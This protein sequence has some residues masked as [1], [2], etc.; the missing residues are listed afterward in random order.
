MK[1]KGFTLVELLAVIAI[2]AILVIIAL[3]N[4]LGMFNQAKKNTFVTEVQSI[5]STG[6]TQFVSDSMGD[7][8]KFSEGIKYGRY[9]GQNIGDA[10]SGFKSLDLQGTTSIDYFIHFNLAGAV[11]AFYAT[12]GQFQFA[13]KGDGLK[14]EEITATTIK[15]GDIKDSENNKINSLVVT[16]DDYNTG[17][18]TIADA[19]SYLKNDWSRVCID[20]NGT[21]SM[22]RN[23]GQACTT[24]TS[25]EPEEPGE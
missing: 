18:I 14:K 1:K 2:L 5:Y 7:M 11:V 4:V 15:A 21:G 23:D 19:M 13:Y 17:V 22:V 20:A 8:T 25:T 6:E 24:T 10:S 9:K 3:P 16:G 12:D